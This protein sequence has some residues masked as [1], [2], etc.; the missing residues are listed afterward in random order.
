M[1][2]LSLGVLFISFPSFTF[3]SCSF[4]LSF[5][6]V[7][8]FLSGF[9]FFY[10]VFLGSWYVYLVAVRSASYSDP[11]ISIS[12]FDVNE[13]ASRNDTF[14]STRLTARTSGRVL[15]RWICIGFSGFNSTGTQPP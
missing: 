13:S 9:L 12:S 4:V 2:F 3:V 7:L 14:V 8:L 5:R 15:V 1:W 10:A 6:L 11:R